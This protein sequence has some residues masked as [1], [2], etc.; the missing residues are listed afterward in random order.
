MSSD[1][2]DLD[3]LA[4]TSFSTTAE[5]DLAARSSLA[6]ARA[7]RRRVEAKTLPA[8]TLPAKPRSAA[9]VPPVPSVK[10]AR[11]TPP[12]AVASRTVRD[13][14]RWIARARHHDQVQLAAVRSPL[15]RARLAEL[16]RL[17]DERLRLCRELLALSTVAP[18]RRARLVAVVQAVRA[19][20]LP[21]GEA[22]ARPSALRLNLDR[23]AKENALLAG[24]VEAA[25]SPRVSTAALG[26]L[27]EDY[28]R[29]EG[30]P[31]PRFAPGKGKGPAAKA[32]G[33]RSVARDY[34]LI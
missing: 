5:L 19:A 4:G 18:A 10:R 14:Q 16:V 2:S 30:R 22:V 8:K 7:L 15:K 3:T 23:L 32:E 1:P 24:I 27:V 11:K 9:P 20:D 33:A 12:G 25:A 28:L 34:R 13:L 31:S 26:I 6:R 21:P 17:R 29:V